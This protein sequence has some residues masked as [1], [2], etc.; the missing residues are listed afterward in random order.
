MSGAFKFLR[1]ISPVLVVIGLYGLVNA[2]LDWRRGVRVAAWPTIPGVVKAA[3][4]KQGRSG[5][6]DMGHGNNPKTT[7]YR[8]AIAYAYEVDGVPVQGTRVQFGAAKNERV[9]AAAQ[10]AVA[11]YTPGQTVQVHYNPERPGESALEP[12]IAPFWRK[13]LLFAVVMLVLG[14]CGWLAAVA[15]R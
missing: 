10:D 11:R 7:V 5:A 9:K 13:R 14:A 1:D 3:G 2:I 4:V 15:A 8:A 6:S 12:G